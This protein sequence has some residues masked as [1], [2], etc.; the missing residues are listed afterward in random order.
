[1]EKRGIDPSHL[2]ALDV[3]AGDGEKLTRHYAPRMGS[4]EAWERSPEL[5]AALRRNL[6]SDATVRAVDSHDEIKRVPPA[7]FDFIFVDNFLSPEEHFALFPHIWDALSDDATLAIDVLPYASRP[8]RKLYPSLFNDEHVRA[9]QE[10][11]GR[12]GDTAMSK[13]ELAEYYEGLARQRGLQPVWDDFVRRTERRL[14]LPVPV[15]F[16]ILIIHLKRIKT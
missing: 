8:T 9:R 10:F 4:I 5:V 3:Y 6:P 13:E 11:F 16:Y 1:M 7:S 12:A 14:G 15:S 2:R